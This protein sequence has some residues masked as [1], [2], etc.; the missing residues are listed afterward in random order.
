MRT[1]RE[2]LIKRWQAG[3][4]ARSNQN[5]G[6]PTKNDE[7]VVCYPRNRVSCQGEQAGLGRAA[8]HNGFSFSLESLPPLACM[9]RARSITR[10]VVCDLDG[11]RNFYN[12]S[13]D[14]EGILGS[15]VRSFKAGENTKEAP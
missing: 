6:P 9:M 10:T 1:E 2:E 15:F 7:N 3:S 14:N 8:G 5:V 4:R 11:G 13:L 12:L